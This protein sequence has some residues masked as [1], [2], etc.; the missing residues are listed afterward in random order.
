MFWKFLSTLIVVIILFLYLP[1]KMN[2]RI[3]GSKK[4][5]KTSPTIFI[6]QSISGTQA[7][8]PTLI[9][10][11]VASFREKPL[12]QAEQLMIESQTVHQGLQ[13]EHWTPLMIEFELLLLFRD[14]RSTGSRSSAKKP[15]SHFWQQQV[16]LSMAQVVH[17]SI[18]SSL[19]TWSGW[20]SFIVW[21]AC[22]LDFEV[23]VFV[24]VALVSIASSSFWYDRPTRI[25]RTRGI[26]RY[27]F[28]IFR[29]LLEFWEIQIY[30]FS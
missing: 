14:L 28:A 2:I 12:A 15:S 10:T 5:T 23:W 3:A 24:A 21:V 25:R 4:I 29:I 8:A 20:M 30:F 27:D 11:K 26:F 22:F 19:G 13:G 7:F 9:L 6:L 1:K 17:L 16:L 18:W